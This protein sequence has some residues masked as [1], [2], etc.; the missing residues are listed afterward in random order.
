MDTNLAFD[1]NMN[2]IMAHDIDLGIIQSQHV[3]STQQSASHHEN[4]ANEKTPS[5]LAELSSLPS[6]IVVHKKKSITNKNKRR[7]LAVDEE[8]EIPTKIMSKRISK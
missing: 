2:D 5:L 1:E 6:S 4:D 3:D 8:K 7:T